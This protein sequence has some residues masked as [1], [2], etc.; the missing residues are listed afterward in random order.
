MVLPK[1]WPGGSAPPSHRAPACTPP[2]T[3]Q[4]QG[5]S[6]LQCACPLG[7]PGPWRYKPRVAR[8]VHV[9]VRLVCSSVAAASH[10]AGVGLLPSVAAHVRAQVVE[11]G[12]CICAAR[13]LACIRL[14]PCVGPEVV[15]DG[16]PVRV[17]T[18]WKWA[19]VTRSFACAAHVKGDGESSKERI[20]E[21]KRESR[22]HWAGLRRLCK[23]VGVHWARARHGTV[24]CCELG[25]VVSCGRWTVQGCGRGTERGC[26]RGTERGCGR[27]RD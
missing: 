16:D 22:R 8:H 9:Q 20:G 3:L 1:M 19:K 10:S 21:R 11:A 6:A 17:P 2:D 15:S 4:L 12:G 5:L 25:T 27:A 26:G 13:Y 14:L 23:A 24:L 18:P 7:S